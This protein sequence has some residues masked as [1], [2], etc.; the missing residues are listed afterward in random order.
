MRLTAGS[1]TTSEPRNRPIRIWITTIA[2]SQGG[3]M[4][5]ECISQDTHFQDSLLSPCTAAWQ[6]VALLEIAAAR[7]SQSSFHLA[8]RNPRT[9]RYGGRVA[10]VF[11]SLCGALAT[12]QSVTDRVQQLGHRVAQHAVS[13]FPIKLART[14]D[15]NATA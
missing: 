10:K 8:T 3:V 7:L 12:S 13:T 1:T 6:D 15:V 9:G 2:A 11:N 14:H 4:I 5:L